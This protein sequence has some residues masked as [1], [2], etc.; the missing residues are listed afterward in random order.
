[1]GSCDG[2]MGNKRWLWNRSQSVPLIFIAQ[3]FLSFFL[4][5]PV[6]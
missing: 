3:L 6:W 2:W 5:D 1:V 4:V